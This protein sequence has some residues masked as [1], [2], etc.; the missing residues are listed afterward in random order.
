[1]YRKFLATGRLI[2]PNTET[3]TH[4]NFLLLQYQE[5]VACRS[6]FVFLYKSGYGFELHGT[7]YNLWRDVCDPYPM[8]S[9][10]TIIT[11]TQLDRQCQSLAADQPQTQGQFNT[12][13]REHHYDHESILVMDFCYDMDE[14]RSTSRV[15]KSK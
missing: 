14:A 13:C 10:S 5:A 2:S 12:T 3:L 11:S 8:Y 15:A 1:M 7:W 6:F 9:I 4:R